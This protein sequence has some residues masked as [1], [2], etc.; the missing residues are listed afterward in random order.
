MAAKP[1]TA[2]LGS[3]RLGVA[4]FRTEI[5]RHL[6]RTWEDVRHME[7]LD[8]LNRVLPQEGAI[9]AVRVTLVGPSP[10]PMCP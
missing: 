7:F 4:A 10:V 5:S 2:V 9:L 8:V 6:A 3:L 1:S